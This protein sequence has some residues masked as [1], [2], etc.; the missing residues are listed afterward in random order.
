MVRCDV[1]E[2]LKFGESGTPAG[3]GGGEQETGSG[4]VNLEGGC[5]WIREQVGDMSTR[6]ASYLT[7]RGRTVTHSLP[8]R[9]TSQHLPTTPK[10]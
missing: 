6:R 9:Q 4:S 7:G 10:S 8:V 3:E 1:V 2:G 5:L